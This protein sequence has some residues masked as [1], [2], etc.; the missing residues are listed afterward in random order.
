LNDILVYFLIGLLVGRSGVLQEAHQRRRTLF[1]AG[2]VATIV[3]AGGAI[4]YAMGWFEGGPAWLGNLGWN[5]ANPGLTAFYVMAITLLCTFTTWGRRAFGVFV[6][7]GR[8]GLTNYLMQSVVMTAMSESYALGWTPST[9]AWT[10]INLGFFFAVQVPL[11]RWWLD[12]F[13]YGPVEWVW[14]SATYGPAQPFKVRPSVPA[15]ALV[16]AP[17]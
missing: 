8:M 16:G 2:G 14:R 3:G 9:T 13:R 17:A 15:E 1:I 6:S 11:S 4:T 10:L 12:C 5:V 7:A